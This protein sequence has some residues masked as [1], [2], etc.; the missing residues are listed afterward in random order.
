MQPAFLCAD[1]CKSTILKSAVTV[2]IVFLIRAVLA[3]YS[4]HTSMTAC[5]T[6][7]VL[8]SRSQC[9]VYVAAGYD[10]GD[11][12][13]SCMSPATVTITIP[14]SFMWCC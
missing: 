14:G 13:G 12:M 8:V 10:T 6:A 7:A 2:V 4:R 1:I 11:N 3:Q 9:A 5:Y